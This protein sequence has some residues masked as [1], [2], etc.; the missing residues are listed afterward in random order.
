M[1]NFIVQSHGK[2]LEKI[3]EKEREAIDHAN[4]TT[5]EYRRQKMYNSEVE[6]FSY[7]ARNSH[8]EAKKGFN[9]KSRRCQDT[10]FLFI[11]LFCL[12]SMLGVTLYGLVQGDPAKYIAPYDGTLKFCG[13]DPGYEAYPKLYLT[14]LMK[15]TAGQIFSSGICVSDCPQPSKTA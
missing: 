4:K 6:D 14:D 5:R 8:F 1:K 13:I 15:P 2:N 10:P 9:H 7:K 3:K 12:G 11:F